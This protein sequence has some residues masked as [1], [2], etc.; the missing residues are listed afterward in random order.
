MKNKCFVKEASVLLVLIMMLSSVGVLAANTESQTVSNRGLATF[1]GNTLH[2][3]G[4][5]PGNYTR[6]Q[7]AIDNAT[8]GDTIFVFDRIYT[9][10]I[11]LDKSLNLI[12]E[13]RFNTIINAEKKGTAV[14][15]TA[16]NVFISNF[17]LCNTGIGQVY[18]HNAAIMVYSSNNVIQNI[19][20]IDT[21]YGMLFQN[22]DENVII[23]N[24]IKAYWDGIS[25]D[26]SKNCFLRNNSMNGSG[27]LAYDEHDIDKTNTVNDKTVYY[28]YLKDGITVPEDAGQVILI[29]C[30][31]FIIENLHIS[32]T[33]L[34][35]SIFNSNYN[36]VRNNTVENNTD[37]GIILNNS[38]Y[39]LIIKNKVLNN[40]IGIALSAGGL[41]VFKINSNCKYNVISKNNIVYNTRFGLLVVK[42]NYNTISENNF[43]NSRKNTIQA[44]IVRSKHNRFDS[45]YWDNWIGVK[46]H[47][48]KRCPKVIPIFFMLNIGESLRY[49]NI[50][51]GFNLDWHPAQQPYNII[52]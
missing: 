23:N 11:D 3:G 44:K 6:I 10:I 31:N 27:L 25:L 8:S 50:P 16:D 43:I 13:N 40:P 51:M 24:Y 47:F 17:T 34:G 5:G 49:I 19:N 41:K 30:S 4:I 2:V 20:C 14:R 46:I 36:V 32:K 7:D 12:G 1:T 18:F 35:I 21:N 15:I 28:Y 42:S 29:N 9:E 45:N 39:N 33:T 48:I 26:D 38:N 52:V 22:S 37:F